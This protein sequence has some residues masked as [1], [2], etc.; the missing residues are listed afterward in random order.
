MA[1]VSHKGAAGRQG[2]RFDPTPGRVR[3]SPRWL[4]AGVGGGALATLALAQGGPAAA[5]AL[6]VAGAAGAAY[7]LL[8]EPR[9][10]RL[11]RV[12]LRL[13]AL[14][15]AL[16]GLRIGQISDLHLGMR[17][18]AANSRW[19]AECVAGE[20]PDLLALTGDFVSYD[21]AIAELPGVLAPLAGAS[22]PLGIYAVP[23][24][25]DY[26]E[27]L[28]A[29]RRALE[30]LGVTFLVNAHRALRQGD[31][32]L[33]VAGVDDMWDGQPDLPGALAGAP[34]GSF[35]LLLSHCPDTADEAAQHGVGVQLS[36]HTHGGHM[37]LP[38]LGSFC[39]PRYGWRYAVG[40]AHVG[41]TQ[42]YVSRGIGGMPLRLGCP[43]EATIITLRRG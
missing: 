34:A 5:V 27:G 31:A 8:H 28:P 43:P 32:S 17:F 21:H 33:V 30:P 16:D 12:T 37:R 4:G 7:A 23:G 39:L 9:S 2:R 36:G 20:R 24:N 1:T 40:H 18:T 35:T 25:H 13:P 15:R 19:A 10:P 14:P 42:L 22:F 41:A 38:W 6:G 29:I 3:Y 26:W 11:E